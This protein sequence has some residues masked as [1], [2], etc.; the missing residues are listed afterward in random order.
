MAIDVGASLGLP[1]TSA[2]FRTGNLVGWA[3][4][5][6]REL[7]DGTEEPG[8]AIV[9]SSDDYDAGTIEAT[10]PD[11]LGGGSYGFTVEGVTDEDY[12]KIA[13]GISGSRPSMKLYLWWRDTNAS[14]GG[15]LANLAGA[16]GLISP[17]SKPPEDALVAVLRVVNVTRKRG[18][19]RY[20]AVISARELAYDRVARPIASRPLR[21][22][23]LRLAME[24]AAED[25]NL[26]LEVH[27]IAYTGGDV[28]TYAEKGSTYRRF[29]GEAA[30]SME[31]LHPNRRGRG[32]LL[33]R[34]GTLHAGPRPIPLT[35]DAKPLTGATGFI[36]AERIAAEP[37]PE[38]GPTPPPPPGK[39]RFT[40][41][42]KGRPDIK[43]GDLVKFDPPAEEVMKTQPSFGAALFGGLGASLADALVPELGDALGADAVTLYV[44]SV[45]HTLGRT[46]GFATVV[47]GVEVPGANDKAWDAAAM[48]EPSDPAPSGSRAASASA[49][50]AGAAVAAIAAHATEAARGRRFAEVGEVRRFTHDGGAAAEPP[51]Q[52]ETVW[53]GLIV[54]D[55]KENAARRLPVRRKEP[56]PV[57][58]I[59]YLT[60][61]AWG[62]CGLVLP[63][64]PGTRVMLEHR[65]GDGTDAVDI[66]ALWE[67]GKGPS[68]EPGDWWL[69]LPVGVPSNKRQTVADKESAPPEHSGKAS[70]DLVDADGNRVITVGELTVRVGK[71]ALTTAG[72]R[73]TRA[74]ETGSITIEHVAGGS[75]IVMKSD[76]TVVITA[77][78]IEMTATENIKMTA[79]KVD[80]KVSDKMDV[81]G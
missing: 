32:M 31:F 66:G 46:K 34:N 39:R 10:L 27:G 6:F 77:K 56:S 51:S 61:F 79:A 64:Y 26:N 72:T 80:V 54:P 33:I 19:R 18:E 12:R 25:A 75:S 23:D 3:L 60:P 55:G 76:G 42:L 9:L 7:P 73:P 67:S 38:A 24:N 14:V 74:S 53:R 29:F 35:G 8:S 70:N 4:E 58:G 30:Q 45:K 1:G 62:K 16:T 41:T 68:S 36:E 40:L 15:Y 52:T 48:D 47:T 22:A 2:A 50:G 20:E 78:N 57:A 71:D 81:H 65:N 13:Q 5:F 37:D 69:I 63:R 21:A 17:A 49:S 59:P 11:G 44:S 43:P 28:R